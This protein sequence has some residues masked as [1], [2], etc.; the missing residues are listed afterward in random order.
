MTDDERFEAL[1]GAHAGAVL[2][3]ARRRTSA[4][5]A[6]DVMAE[7]FLIAWR[8]LA[9]VP[10]DE[11]IW[12]LGVARRVLANQ[13]RGQTRQRAL[14]ERLA[15]Q[16]PASSPPLGRGPR[17][18]RVLRALA[19]L[20]EDDREALLLLGWE[21][22]SHAEAARVLGIRARTFSV[23]AHRARRRFAL[24]LA[25]VELAPGESADASLPVEVL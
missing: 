9:D 4:A 19:G 3:Y 18:E 24:A 20:R 2:A 5:N 1:Y 21:E 14:S 8:R 10:H 7:V 13:R 22:L 25:A 6:D 16:L 17:D 11:R 15:P 23:R 12:L